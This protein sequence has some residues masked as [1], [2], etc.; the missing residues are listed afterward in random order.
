MQPVYIQRIASIHPQGNHSQENNP[1]VNDSPDVSAN[2]P[3]L[4][5]CEPDYKDIIANATL[6]R[7][8][9]RIVKMGVA[10][11]LECMGELSPEKI[12]GII[13]ATGLG[14]LVDTEKF[15]NN[16]LNNEERML[17]PTPF[18]QSTFNTIGAQIAL[19]HQIHAY[20][21]TYVHRGLSFES[22]LLDAMM[23]IEEG[24]ENILVGAM[25]E[26]TETS[27]IIQQRCVDHVL[28]SG[29]DINVMVFDTEVYSNTGGQSSKATKTGATAQ[30]AAGGKETKKKDLAGMAMTYG[31]VYVAQIA[32]GADF[33]QTVKAIAEA[34][35]Y[36]GPSLIIAYAPCINHGI[37]K[38]MS[39]AQTEEQLAVECGY[40][41]NFRYNPA[42]E[43]D[44][45]SLDSKAPK[46]EGY[47]DFLNG[48]VRYNAL[49]RANPAK[50]D[51]LFALNE[52]EAMERY[53]Y[54]NK[55]V[56][57]YAAEKEDK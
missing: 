4:Q 52:Q 24:N 54:L 18:I 49:K 30:F 53:D 38:G 13:T 5:A 42:A 27:Y 2:R 40:W 7:R 14:C 39:K 31:Y 26:M 35:A 45:F 10:C 23:K 46:A 47:Q 1:K 11:G 48:E 16:L 19:I 57:V 8:M 34:E 36:P 29:R 20:N 51:K 6:R 12:G 17:N 33:N 25:D 50:A 55:L 56:T 41:N 28:A 43:G 44:K 32:M 3:F 21:M 22:A 15:L 9:S 37:K